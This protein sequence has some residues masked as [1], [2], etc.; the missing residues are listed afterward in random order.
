VNG[1]EEHGFCEPFDENTGFRERMSDT[2]A[3]PNPPEDDF[4]RF[5]KSLDADRSRAADMYEDLR[6]RLLRFF[7]C[8]HSSRAEELVDRALAI[9][10]RKVQSGDIRN[11]F[12][13]ALGIAR[14]VHLEASAELRRVVAV[15][16]TPRGE[17]SFEDPRYADG[18]VS[19]EID[20]LIRL[21]CLRHCRTKLPRDDDKLVIAYYSAYGEKQKA[22]RERLGRTMGITMNALRVRTNRIRE[23]LEGCVTECV[24]SRQ[25]HLAK[26]YGRGR[27]EICRD[28]A[29]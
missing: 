10:E 12:G 20:E 28:Q 6:R 7:M 9:L 21:H 27:A 4:D 1:G 29:G 18:R 2:V 23:R 22:H 19:E 8:N 16:D 3:S 5:L 25:G 15:E 13:Y 11:V 17:N 14:K 26:L 24:E